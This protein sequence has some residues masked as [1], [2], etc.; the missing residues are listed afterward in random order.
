MFYQVKHRRNFKYY[1]CIHGELI[2]SQEFPDMSIDPDDSL[3]YPWYPE[4]DT[5]ELE[6]KF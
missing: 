4:V 2:V 6:V 5:H 1:D 3:R